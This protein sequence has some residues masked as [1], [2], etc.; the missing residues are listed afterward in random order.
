MH[1]VSRLRRNR[2]YNMFQSPRP[3]G[4]TLALLIAAIA[5]ALL[6]LGLSD[7]VRAAPPASAESSEQSDAA[8]AGQGQVD[9]EDY[10]DE[11]PLDLVPLVQPNAWIRVEMAPYFRSGT[12]TLTGECEVTGIGAT[13]PFYINFKK[14]K[15]INLGLAEEIEGDSRCE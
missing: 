13:A 8:G 14:N 12:P 15:V 5:V 7:V 4:K 6:L 1:R 3:E 10:G 9:D 11:P 2:A